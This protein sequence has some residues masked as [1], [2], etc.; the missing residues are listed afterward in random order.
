M[1]RISV[2]DA[3]CDTIF[4]CLKTGEGLDS[5]GGMVSLERTERT[6]ERYAQFYALWDDGKREGHFTY[7]ELRDC[8][9]LQMKRNRSRIVQC[10]TGAE[11]ERAYGEGKAAAFLT[12]EGAELLDCSLERLE[13][14]AVDGVMAVN[15]TWNH[16]NAISGSCREETHR[17]L[18]ELGCR[19]V[20][21]MEQL[22]IF[23]DV[24][25]LSDAGFWD[26]TEIATRPIL[27]SHS[28]A[29]AVWEHTRNLTNDQIT[30]IIRSQGVIGLNFYRHFIGGTMDFDAVRAHLDH[31]LSLGG[32]GHVVLGGDWD[33]CDTID[34]LPAIVDLEA[35]YEYLLCRNYDE[36]I[37]RDLFYNNLMRVVS[38]P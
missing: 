5:N 25:H 22:G 6:F 17:G 1:N 14:A 29:R 36:A 38:L 31:I 9:R 3:H 12:V 13:Q 21:K 32:A 19:F 26:V 20:R 34:A 15:L 35:L 10:R 11:A 37:L 8:F 30:A 28:N 27:A 16:A 4:R 23:V 24:S 18:S 7:D 33:G 2:F